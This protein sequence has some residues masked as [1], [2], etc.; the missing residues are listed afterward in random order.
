MD[1]LG[2][3]IRTLREARGVKQAALARRLGIPS[4]TLSNYELGPNKVPAA[5]VPKIAAILGVSIS[6]LYGVEEPPA[7]L[8]DD[9]RLAVSFNR[10][11][12]TP[13]NDDEAAKI[14]AAVEFVLAEREYRRQGLQGA[15]G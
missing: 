3:R 6:G 13:L 2:T 8:L 4:Q 7:A 14:R 12:E 9:P 5:L 1:D 11:N 10:L 15:G